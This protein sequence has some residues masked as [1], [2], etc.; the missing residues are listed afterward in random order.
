M[1]RFGAAVLAA[2][3]GLIVVVQ[4][5]RPSGALPLF[6]GLIITDPF[7]YLNP[8][9]GQL[10]D[11]SSA[12]QDITISGGRVPDLSAATDESPPQ[13]QVFS[14]AGTFAAP[15]GATRV[16]FTVTPIPPPAVLPAK[17]HIVGNVY[18]FAAIADNGLVSSILHG[19]SA[20]I[21]MRGPDDVS[22][23]TIEHL[24]G[25]TWKALKTESAGVQ[26]MWLANVSSLGDFALVAPGAPSPTPAPGGSSVPT[27]SGGPA[28][29]H[30][31]ARPRAR[32]PWPRPCP[33]LR[34][35]R[36]QAAHP[37]RESRLSACPRWL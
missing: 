26:S 29:L 6:D 31:P 4:L 28:S 8:P 5:V 21:V 36:R 37:G 22:R 27:G 16:T 25:T 34:R 19:K 15:A 30:Q 12:S 33:L 17:G 18:S 11:P 24:V 32:Y 20:T 1:R 10:G 14:T 9:P 13:A 2:G 7:R 23:A 35:R 3:F